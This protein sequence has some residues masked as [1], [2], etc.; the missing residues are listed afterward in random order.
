ML[1]AKT[2]IDAQAALRMNQ[3]E[4]YYADLF[5]WVN[6]DADR[7][8][9]MV[10][11]G[12]VHSGATPQLWASYIVAIVNEQH[13]NERHGQRLAEIRQWLSDNGLVSGEDFTP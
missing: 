3:A 5:A 11:S 12:G 4:S 6:G 1:M 8:T 2:L 9:R 10:L 13:V 7:F